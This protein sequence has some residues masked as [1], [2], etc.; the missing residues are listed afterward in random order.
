MPLEAV[1]AREPAPSRVDGERWLHRAGLALVLALALVAL[2]R[3]LALDAE[4][5]DG[6]ET[7]FAA[8]A[9]AGHRDAPFAIW[10][11]VLL[12]VL[13]SAFGGAGP[14]SSLAWAFPHVLS[15]LA[16]GG[17]ALAALALA[18]AAGASRLAATAAA[19]AVALDRL[20][21]ADAPLGLP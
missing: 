15:V 16:Y 8:R 14:G 17:L 19:T 5:Y 12:V 11:C 9:V 18:R 4:P 7:R 3:P 21:F 13:E 10:P 6:Y 1:S 2:V 20:A